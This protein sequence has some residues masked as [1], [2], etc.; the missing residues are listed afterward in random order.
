MLQMAENYLNSPKIDEERKEIDDIQP[1]LILKQLYAMMREMGIEVPDLEEDI[2][3]E[4]E[5]SFD[6]NFASKQNRVM[7]AMMASL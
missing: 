4:P 6:V 3:P 5:K 2:T 7:K 1:N